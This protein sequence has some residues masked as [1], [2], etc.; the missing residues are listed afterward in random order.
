MTLTGERLYS[1]GPAPGS[2]RDQLRSDYSKNLL[3]GFHALSAQRLA[4]LARSLVFVDGGYT[5]PRASIQDSKLKA[6][7]K[8]AG[9]ALVFFG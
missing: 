3:D 8:A 1:A 5:C 7:A 2:L 6:S 4:I 9:L